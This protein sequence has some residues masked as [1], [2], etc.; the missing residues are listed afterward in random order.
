MH[1]SYFHAE[2]TDTVEFLEVDEIQT[3]VQKATD[4]PMAEM[5]E[6]FDS[7]FTELG[8]LLQAEGIQPAGP[9]FSLHH[10]QPTD[11]ATFEVG[12]PVDKRLDAA[13]STESGVVLAPSIIPG[14]QIA[15][16]SYVGSF[17]GLPDAWGAFMQAIAAAGKQPLIPLWEIYLTEPTPD[18]DPTTLRTDI[19]TRV[20]G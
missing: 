15:R 3:I 6:V 4:H 18:M 9:A 13:R 14:G 7:T 17:D 10:R 19:F 2:L 12:F 5:A 11:S 8:P 20:N 1:H 16:I